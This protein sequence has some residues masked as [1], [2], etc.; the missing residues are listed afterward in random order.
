MYNLF[1]VYI[2]YDINLTHTKTHTQEA[3]N[4]NCIFMYY[5]RL[6]LD[7]MVMEKNY[8]TFLLF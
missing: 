5:V 8:V 4:H 1:S 2:Q 3:S 7:L 6:K